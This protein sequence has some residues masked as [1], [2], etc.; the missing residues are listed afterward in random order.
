MK[1]GLT[2]RNGSMK[3][4]D[5]TNSIMKTFEI[6]PVIRSAAAVLTA[7]CLGS[8]ILPVPGTSICASASEAARSS[9]SETGNFNTDTSDAEPDH[10][11]ISEAEYKLLKVFKEKTGN[12]TTSDF[13]TYDYDKDGKYE[14]F[15]LVGDEDDFGAFTGT[16]YFVT[17]K[18]VET[19]LEDGVFWPYSG[20]LRMLRFNDCGFYLIG[21]YYTTGDVTYVFGVKNGKWYEHPFSRQGMSL[22]QVDQTNE[23]TITLSEY[24]GMKDK[25]SGYYSAHTWKTYYM[26]WNGD[27]VEYGGL[28]ISEKDLLAYKNAGTYV[29]QIKSQGYTIDSIYYRANGIININYSIE[30]DT[31]IDYE[32]LTLVLKDKA[33]TPLNIYNDPNVTFKTAADLSKAS[34]GGTYKACMFADRAVYPDK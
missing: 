7:A 34:Y 5:M 33:V 19:V 13:C 14:A 15:A 18:S 25:Q 3:F 21:E 8:M 2:E 31:F 11:E 1:C 4:A 26:Y 27:F 9:N 29:D 12:L 32:N 22:R 24:D 16:L 28:K 17:D 20:D 10:A 6:R 23:M 30:N